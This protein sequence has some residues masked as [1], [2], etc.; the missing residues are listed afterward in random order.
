MF[1]EIFRNENFIVC[2]KAAEVLSVPAR[3]KNDARLCLGLELQKQ[4]NTQIFPVHRLDFEVSGLIIYALNAKSHQQAQN[5]FLKK[6]I[7]KNYVAITSLQDFSHWPENVKTDRALLDLSLSENSTCQNK[8][9][10]KTQ[11]QR[12]KRRSFESPRG[13]WAETRASVAS[14]D[15]QASVIWDLFPITGKPHQL[16]FELSRR[17][18]P[19]WGDK[20][21]GSQI[22]WR[23]AGIAL[24]AYALDLAKIP[25][26]LGLPERIQI[27]K[28]EL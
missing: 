2:D 24:K 26:R 13:E 5:W 12:G 9:I 27:E 18:F 14:V 7:Q 8:F 11:I 6:Q 10:W 15:A 17:G 20:L 16:R 1:K 21:Y 28:W 22:A 25:N 4:L 19:I 23:H 3:E